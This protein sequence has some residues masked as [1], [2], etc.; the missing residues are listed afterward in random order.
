MNVESAMVFGASAT[1]TCIHPQVLKACGML[2]QA[3]AQPAPAAANPNYAAAASA[4]W[5]AATA[6]PTWPGE[7]K[8][9]LHRKP[10][11]LEEEGW[12]CCIATMVDC[13]RVGSSEGAAL[14]TQCT[15]FL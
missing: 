7:H 6:M 11:L 13:Q 12:A 3:P 2:L 5:A 9:N 8:Q 10:G 1:V 4:S 14:R 15:L